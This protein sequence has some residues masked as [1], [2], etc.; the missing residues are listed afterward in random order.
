GA[1]VTVLLLAG[2]GGCC[3][4][5]GFAA[6]RQNPLPAAVPAPAHDLTMAAKVALDEGFLGFFIACSAIPRGDA[7][8]HACG[9]LQTLHKLAADNGWNDTPEQLHRQPPAPDTAALTACEQRKLAFEWLTFASDYDPPVGA[10]GSADW[11]AQTANA[12]MHA[13]VFEHA[14][15]DRPWLLCL[16][17]YRMGTAV[18]DFSLFDIRH[19]HHDLGFNLLM[20]ILPL[21]GPSRQTRLSGGGYLDGSPL[22]MFH[23]QTQALWDIRRTLAWLRSTHA[24]GQVGVLGYSLGGYNAALL[25]AVEPDLTCVIAGIP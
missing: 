23:A 14:D 2:A 7:V 1:L 19:L 6:L 10:P 22:R 20:P 3:L 13:R 24:G 16:H 11:L 25:A 5:S 21:H 15:A 12:R 17:G 18:A 8:A 4:L 9:H